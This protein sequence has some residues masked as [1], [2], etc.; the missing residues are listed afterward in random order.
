LRYTELFAGIGGF[1]CGLEKANAEKIRNRNSYKGK[2]RKGEAGIQPDRNGNRNKRDSADI[3]SGLRQVDNGYFKCIWAN[4]IEKYACQIYR[5]NFGEKELIKGD[6]R[7]IPAESIPDFDLLTAGFPC[8]SFSLAGKRKGF[9]DTRG[10][11]FFE[12]C[13]I[14]KAKKPCLLLL[15][16]VQGLLSHDRGDTFRIIL[17]SLSE[18]GYDCEWEVL[19]S[20][21]FGVP[22]NRPRVFIVGHL[23][24]TGGQKVFPLGKGDRKNPEVESTR[25]PV[26]KCL[27]ARGQKDLHSGL[28][29]I[30]DFRY[31]KG[32][33]IRR[34]NICPTI[35]RQSKGQDY[36][37]SPLLIGKKEIRRL[38]PTE[39][40]RIQGF[41]DGWTKGPPI[42]SWWLNRIIDKHRY[43][44][45]GNAVTVNVIEEI[46]RSIL[47]WT[48]SRKK[49]EAG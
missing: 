37:T 8:Q 44:C 6:I 32:I 41:P 11:L 49:Q 19:N 1:R 39:C 42:E 34:D 28:Q 27:R 26:S 46:G 16:N 10:T 47:K 35:R 14:A 36:S 31:D 23:R 20:K 38:T 12:I 40:E 13:R 33:R 24:G 18:L 29:L 3:G 7:R 25:K 2:I 22:Q 21:D 5:K 4:E 9:G 45:L 17:D 30:G 43:E 15:E 48:G